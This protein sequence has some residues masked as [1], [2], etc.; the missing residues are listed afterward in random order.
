MEID[1]VFKEIVGVIVV[2]VVYA[3]IFI[4]LII[5]VSSLNEATGLNILTPR[6]LIFMWGVLGV[7]TPLAVFTP[8]LKLFKY[9]YI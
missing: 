6:I 7:G 4:F 2:E 5:F 8:I 1:N 3:F 9:G